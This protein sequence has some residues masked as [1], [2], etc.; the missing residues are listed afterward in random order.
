MLTFPQVEDDG[1]HH[2]VGELRVATKEQVKAMLKTVT[3]LL[4]AL[5]DSKK[6]IIS[7]LPRYVS[8]PCCKEGGHMQNFDQAAR[9]KILTDLNAMKRAVRS[10]LYA[11]KI[12]NAY[13]VDPIQ[14]CNANDASSYLDPVHLTPDCYSALAGHLIRLAAGSERDTTEEEIGPSSKRA[15]TGN[16]MPPQYGGGRRGSARGRGGHAT[17][18]RGRAGGSGRGGRRGRGSA[19]FYY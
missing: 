16:E 8:R 2:V 11:E 19:S 12:A 10:H 4:H 18:G 15:R 9:E 14:I 13:I 1:R 3:P 6:L 5:P 17:G 7:C